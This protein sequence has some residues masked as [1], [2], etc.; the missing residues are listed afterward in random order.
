MARARLFTPRGRSSSPRRKTA[1]SQ[2]PGQAGAQTELSSS[3]SVLAVAGA[4]VSLDGITQV[5]L[6]GEFMAYLNAA[7][8]QNDGFD[9]AF[10]IAVATLAAF[11]AGAASVPTPI[12]E[13]GW[14]GWLYHKLFSLRAPAPMDSGAAVDLDI[15]NA[16]TACLR[17][18][19]DSKAM[20]KARVDDVTYAVLQVVETGTAVLRWHFNSRILDKLP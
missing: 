4:A 2:G 10:G 18:D 6:R 5:R 8:A 1:W 11:S 20:R 3:S 12:T 9:C 15:Q 19:V 17:I 14:D 13:I 16:V 7:T